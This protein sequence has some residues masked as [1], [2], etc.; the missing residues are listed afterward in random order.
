MVKYLVCLFLLF[1]SLDIITSELNYVSHRPACFLFWKKEA[2][3][4]II[5]EETREREAV[6]DEHA[7]EVARAV[8]D[9]YA[10]KKEKHHSTS[11]SQQ[12][13]HFTVARIREKKEKGCC[14]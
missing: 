3:K 14:C 13:L 1:S 10:E 6:Q 8:H 7:I 12:T 5:L 9:L 11:S 4:E 2:I